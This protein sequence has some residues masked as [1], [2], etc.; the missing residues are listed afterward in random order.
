MKA[1]KLMAFATAALITVLISGAAQAQIGTEVFFKGIEIATGHQEPGEVY[2]W[3]CYAR[4]T[5]ALPGN[6]TIA[7]DFAGAKEP[8][9]S[10]A[11]TGGNWTLPVYMSSVVLKTRP[12]RI[13]NYQGVLFGSVEAGTVMWDKTGTIGAV[14]LKMLIRGGTQAMAD[15]KG[16]AYLTGTVT[17]VDKGA[18]TFN[19]TI[20]FEF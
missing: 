14:E 5:G 10:G 18:G 2:G 11:V 16:A 4:T 19:G 8:G 1:M 12:I 20:Y 3:M 17:Y 13:D 9:T 6:L 15:L 7:I